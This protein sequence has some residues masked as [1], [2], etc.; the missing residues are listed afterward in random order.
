MPDARTAR[1]YAPDSAIGAVLAGAA[2]GFAAV[3][4]FGSWRPSGDP[5]CKEPLPRTG[6][7]LAQR[8]RR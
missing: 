6:R 1:R 3:Y 8:W 7:P 5:A 2:I 4:D